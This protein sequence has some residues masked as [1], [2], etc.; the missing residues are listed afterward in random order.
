M[1]AMNVIWVRTPLTLLNWHIAQEIVELGRTDSVIVVSF[2]DDVLSAFHEIAPDVTTSPGTTAVFSWL[3][4][5][6]ELH[7]N[8]RLLQLPPEFE[9]FS[10]S[11]LI[12]DVVQEFQLRAADN[13][14]ALEVDPP[15]EN[16]CV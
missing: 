15:V 13:D 16:T 4:G 10:L 11:E 3:I 2:D 14:V 9:R 12:H 6:A 5:S 1:H 8:D 7:P